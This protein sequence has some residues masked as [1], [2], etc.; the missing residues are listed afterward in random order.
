MAGPPT[1]AFAE[2]AWHFGGL[3]APTG[4]VTTLGVQGT[5]DPVE[6]WL[7]VL[8]GFWDE[9][10]DEFVPELECERG[11]VKVGPVATGP[12][13]SFAIGTT[14]TGQGQGVSPNVSV[15][16]RKEVEGISGRYSGRMYWPG[17]NEGRIEANG[18]LTAQAQGLFQSAF[19]N[20]FTHLLN[21]GLTPVVF[22]T[23]SS[24]PRNISAV[25]VQN[26]VATQRRR[27]RR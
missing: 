10:R 4:A 20:A 15:L 12:T 5:M 14:G 2:L 23:S 26:R 16:V 21:A 1:S 18:V 13:Y 27:L 7:G 24:D 3:S 25:L 6:G 19:S 9:V 8:T 22:S 11:T 17:C